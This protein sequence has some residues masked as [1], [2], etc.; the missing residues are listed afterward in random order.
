V[1]RNLENR[2]RIARNP[3]CG[4]SVRCGCLSA[5]GPEWPCKGQKF[6]KFSL[7]FWADRIQAIKYYSFATGG[8]L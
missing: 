3:A 1:A 8:W 6:C 4:Y 5:R 2:V 7:P